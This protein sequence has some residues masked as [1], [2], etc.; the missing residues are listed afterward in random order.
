MVEGEN[1]DKTFDPLLNFSGAI[2]YGVAGLPN[3][4]MILRPATPTKGLVNRLYSAFSALSVAFY[5]EGMIKYA[6]G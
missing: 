5:C 4:V 2:R 6:Y 1:E 3:Q